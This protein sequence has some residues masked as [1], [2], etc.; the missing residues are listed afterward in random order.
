MTWIIEAEAKVNATGQS[1][2]NNQLQ[3][4][5]APSTIQIKKQ[6]NE[7]EKG[8]RKGPEVQQLRKLFDNTN[9]SNKVTLGSDSRVLLQQ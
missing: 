7:W 4:P 9:K 6:Q 8:T 1:Y 5:S 3:T 2:I